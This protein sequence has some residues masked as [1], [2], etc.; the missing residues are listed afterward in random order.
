MTRPADLDGRRRATRCWVAETLPGTGPCDGRL[1]RAHLIS[2]QW[3]ER[4]FRLGRSGGRRLSREERE[5]LREMQWDP[6][7]WRF[8]CGGIAGNG[9]HHGQLDSS[10]LDITRAML[11]AELEQYAGEHGL[12]FALDRLYGLREEAA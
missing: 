10:A 1:V 4:Q 7:V 5:A 6:R 11:P 8:V 12:G 2:R 3:I 9:G